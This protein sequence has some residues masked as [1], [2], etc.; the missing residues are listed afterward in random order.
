MF[1]TAVPEFILCTSY[2]NPVVQILHNVGVFKVCTSCS[3]CNTPAPWY[4]TTLQDT[5]ITLTRCYP[6]QNLTSY[7][8]GILTSRQHLNSFRTPVYQPS[9]YV[10]LQSTQ[11]NS[12]P[13]PFTD[14]L[15][16]YCSTYYN[17]HIYIYLWHVYCTSLIL[18][19]SIN[20]FTNATWAT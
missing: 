2:C 1:K 17:I 12:Q 4:R 14:I 6:W 5:A 18:T 9:F 10:L 7:Y 15:G 11:W 20:T 19:Y 16:N 8:T 3:L 13:A